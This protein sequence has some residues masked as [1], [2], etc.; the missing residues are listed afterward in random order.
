MVL[1]EVPPGLLDGLPGEDQEAIVEIVDKPVLLNEFRTAVTGPAQTDAS[2][3]QLY[4]FCLTDRRLRPQQ[5]V[6]SRHD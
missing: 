2:I 3:A 6:R 1:T 5:F 4:C